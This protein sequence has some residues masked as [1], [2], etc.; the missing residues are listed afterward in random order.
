MDYYKP[1][2]NIL[3]FVNKSLG[4]H[5]SIDT[6]NKLKELF[7][8]ENH[9]KFGSKI[10]SETKK[11]ISDSIKKFVITHN[12]RYKGFKGKFSPQY[13]IGGDFVF[14][15]NLKGEEVIFPSINAARQH[16]RVR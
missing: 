12:H 10:S 11:A 6:I 16:F 15:Y 8:K 13:G 3:K 14:C 7:K 9:P 1:R 5:H 2:Y 4:F